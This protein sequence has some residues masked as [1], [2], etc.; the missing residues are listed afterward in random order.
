MTPQEL[1]ALILSDEQATSLFNQGKDWECSL[2]CMDIAPKVRKKL[3]LTRIGLLKLFSDANG[4][5]G[6]IVANAILD[7]IVA[8]SAQNSLV[9]KVYDFTGPSTNPDSIFD[10][11]DGPSL[12]I[13]MAPI[14]SGGCG[15]TEEQ[16]APLLSAAFERPHISDLEIEFVRN[17]I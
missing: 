15:F 2:R 14:D 11:A 5:P 6:A 10:W 9:A 4:L 17:R 16:L 13:L 7:S 3:Q 8:I 12:A 1:K